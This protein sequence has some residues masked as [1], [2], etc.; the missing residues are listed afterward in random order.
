M[1]AAI[2]QAD[3]TLFCASLMGWLE[4]T[5]YVM[6]QRAGTAKPTEDG[7]VPPLPKKDWVMS[8]VQTIGNDSMFSFGI[9]AALKGDGAAVDTVE[10]TLLEQLGENYPGSFALWH[11]RQDYGAADTLETLDDH[12]GYNGQCLLA[13]KVMEPKEIWSAGVRFL[14][15]IRKSNFVV[16]L[17][18]QL[19]AWNRGH[20]NKILA[21]KGSELHEAETNVPGV[22]EALKD[23]RSDQ[24]FI[25][26]LLLAGMP[27]VDMELNEDYMGLLKSV[28]RRV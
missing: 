18:P 12:V 19:A 10:K 27:A 22:V 28:A 20:W 1:N 9:A 4:V 17:V 7:S 26:A 11:F 16:E 14:E 25:A 6:A 13:G 23:E 3:P 2:L 15:K 21:E 8:G 5:A 24:S